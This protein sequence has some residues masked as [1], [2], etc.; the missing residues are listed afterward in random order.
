MK[1]I[2]LTAIALMVMAVA[3]AQRVNN[4]A[5]NNPANYELTFDMRRLAVTLDLNAEQ[6]DAVEAI[7]NQMNS[8][9]ATAATARGHRRAAMMHGA[10]ATDMRN[11]RRVLNDSQFRTYAMLLGTTLQNR[12]VI[13]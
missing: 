6:M 5:V 4:P 11:M 7:T 13:R 1:K 10:I 12:M 2:V 9:L 3:S 8:Q